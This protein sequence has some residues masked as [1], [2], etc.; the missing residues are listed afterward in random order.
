VK[1]IFR[2]LLCAAVLLA[3]NVILLRALS[4]SPTESEKIVSS[5]SAWARAAV[6]GDASLMA[7]FMSDDYVEIFAETVPG[8][9]QGRWAT[10]SKA[11]WTDSVRSGR[12][13]YKSVDLR[14]LKVHLH[15][16]IATVTGEYSQVGTKEGKDISAA[17][18]YVNTWV[19]KNGS[20]QVVASV[21]P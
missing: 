16:D 11:E 17:G 2:S 20:W 7:S 14:N 5:E 10:T 3:A 1:P 19:K 21:F 15:G 4:S 9:T 12:E 8:A 18:L 13:K 6:K